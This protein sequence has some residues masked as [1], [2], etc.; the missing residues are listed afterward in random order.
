MGGARLMA[1]P[2][3]P[4]PL[5][6]LRAALRLAI[7]LSSLR[8][9][10]RETGLTPSGLEIALVSRRPRHKTLRK[11]QDWYVRHAAAVGCADVHT[12]RAAFE[13]LLEGLPHDRRD[14]LVADTLAKLG[15]A[16]RECGSNPPGW[17]AKLRG[18]G[19]ESG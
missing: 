13:V 15:A 5:D 7:E 2:R 18:D 6:V 16:H 1:P 10:A 3:A 9:V 12:A 14:A 17:M 11:M 8:Q 4:V 19:S